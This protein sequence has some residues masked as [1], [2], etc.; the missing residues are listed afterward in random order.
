MKKNMNQLPIDALQIFGENTNITASG[1]IGAVVD[2]K[3]LGWGKGA[4]VL[5]V[6]LADDTD[7]NETYA[8]V[9]EWST[10]LAFTSPVK[11]FTI[12]ITRGDV[13][14]RFEPINNQV[15]GAAEGDDAMYR[16][17]R[18]RGVLVGTT[19]SLTMTAYLSETIIG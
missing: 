19:P 18:L 12:D 4:L 10:D 13:G 11:D 17:V 8:V 5:D 6:K 14:R 1:N 3:G 9:V 16:F 7:G 2:T 15:A